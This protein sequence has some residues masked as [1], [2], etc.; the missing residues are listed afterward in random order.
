MNMLTT[1]HRTRVLEAKGRPLGWVGIMIVIGFV[2]LVFATALVSVQATI[3]DNMV[4]I[5]SS[6]NQLSARSVIVGDGQWSWL[7]VEA[8]GNLS[9]GLNN[10]QVLS[11]QC[12]TISL[13]QQDE[14]I[15][16]RPILDGN[17]GSS[18]PLNIESIGNL[19]CFSFEMPEG[20]TVYYGGY[21]VLASDLE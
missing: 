7:S 5:S 9:A 1:K 15:D 18:A 12:S 8:S 2:G 14:D 3:P 17:Q 19:Y 11:E 6:H 21:I 13:N 10:S 16:A 20:T 4:T